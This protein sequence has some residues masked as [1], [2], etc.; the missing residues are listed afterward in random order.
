MPPHHMSQALTVK[1]L[2]E[3]LYAQ[4]C[5]QTWCNKAEEGLRRGW[6]LMALSAGTIPPSSKMENYLIK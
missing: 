5:N 1:V 2:R 4:L 6:M 3:E